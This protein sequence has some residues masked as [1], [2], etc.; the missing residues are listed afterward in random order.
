[1]PSYLGD[2]PLRVTDASRKIDKT[3]EV[4]KIWIAINCSLIH[5][6]STQDLA[7]SLIT[8]PHKERVGKHL[9]RL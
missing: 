5:K 4:L 2:F 6:L 7:F 9:M 8:N 1:M 3:Q